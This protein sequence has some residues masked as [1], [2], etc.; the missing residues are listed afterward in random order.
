MPINY[1]ESLSNSAKGDKISSSAAKR[2]MSI[3]WKSMQRFS[4]L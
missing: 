4:T 1:S 3:M 2:Y